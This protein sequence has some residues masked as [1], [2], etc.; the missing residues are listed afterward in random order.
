[1][2]DL[3]RDA[4]MEQGGLDERVRAGHTIRAAKLYPDGSSIK[5][6]WGDGQGTK[7]KENDYVVLSRVLPQQYTFRH[8]LRVCAAGS[9]GLQLD[10][11]K[12]APD[13]AADGERRRRGW[14][15]RWTAT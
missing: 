14:G 6:K 3:E 2:L 4:D 8:A 13:D 5:V 10:A 15:G 11:G 7:F 12:R 1:M 9:S